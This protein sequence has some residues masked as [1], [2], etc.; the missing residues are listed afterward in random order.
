MNFLAIEIKFVVLTPKCDASVVT[1]MAWRITDA[2]LRG[3]IDNTQSGSVVG[4][5]WLRGRDSPISLRLDGDAWRDIAGTKLTFTNPEPRPV[6]DIVSLAAEQRGSVGDITASRKCCVLRDD[7]STF[8]S[9]SHGFPDEDLEWR[10]VLYVEWFNEAGQRIVIE[11]AAF[12]MELG[13]R[14][15]QMESEEEEAQKLANLHAMREFL[16]KFIAREVRTKH[17]HVNE[18]MDEFEWE[19]RLKESDRVSEAFGEVMEKYRSDPDHE[20]K[21]AFVMGWDGLLNAMADAEDNAEDMEDDY[22]EQEDFLPQDDE[23]EDVDWDDLDRH[24]T[25]EKARKLADLA[26]DIV[27]DSDSRDTPAHVLVDRLLQVHGKLGGVLFD[28]GEDDGFAPEAGFVLAVLKRCMNWLNEA[29]GA[30]QELMA[31]E[32]DKDQYAA[33]AHIRS[34]AFEVRDEIMEMRRDL[35]SP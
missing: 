25:S 35:K 20:R 21:E 15:W 4:E 31:C 32:D 10:N 19:R 8:V 24:P 12:H 3:T 22:L 2:V 7:P 14:E 9:R 5:L 28:D 29:I 1:S 17:D 34:L 27:P 23:V 30:C 11:S 16:Q 18:E 26:L 6:E 13:E 33:L